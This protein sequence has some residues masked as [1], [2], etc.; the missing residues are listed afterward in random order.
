MTAFPTVFS[1]LIPLAAAWRWIPLQD[2]LLP[3]RA[4]DFITRFSSPGG[5]TLVAVAGGGLASGLMV[6]LTL[7]AVVGAVAFPGWLAFVYVLVG[8]LLG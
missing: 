5:P 3:Q 8:A 7:L 2:W 6:P 4:A 1:L